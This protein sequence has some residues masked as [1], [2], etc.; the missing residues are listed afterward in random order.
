MG[1]DISDSNGFSSWRV[2]SYSR[3][4]H[5]R[6]HLIL[7]TIDYLKTLGSNATQ[8]LADDSTEDKEGP[9]TLVTTN[10]Q[11]HQTI[12]K[13]LVKELQRWIEP[14]DITPTDVNYEKI[15]DDLRDLRHLDLAGIHYFVQSSDCEG[16]H[17]YEE[18]KH[19]VVWLEKIMNHIP[20]EDGEQDEIL[21]ILGVFKCAVKHYGHVVKS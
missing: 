17:P 20:N 1:L 3:V 11:D 10:H 16:E 18:C 9:T 5:L 8:V 15:S 2:G 7:W 21:G 19:I 12:S 6:K 4:H 13:C 14:S